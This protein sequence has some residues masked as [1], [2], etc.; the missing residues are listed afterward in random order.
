MC[1]ARTSLRVT[2]CVLHSL[3][4]CW[5]ILLLRRLLFLDCMRGGFIVVVIL[6]HSLSHVMFWNA[7]LVSPDD[8]SVWMLLPFIPLVIVGTW[9]PVFVLISGAAC[10]YAVSH[11][12]RRVE[13]DR[14]AVLGKAVRG[15]F[16]Q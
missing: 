3:C 2:L 10:A 11:V 8:V 15:D 5:E 13:E 9:A 1:V 14:N 7:S 6:V 12:L 4:L 16:C